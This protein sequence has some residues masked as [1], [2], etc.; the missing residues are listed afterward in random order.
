MVEQKTDQ[1]V[2]ALIIRG[3][4]ILMEQRAP[5][6]KFFPGQIIFIGGKIED[7]ETRDFEKAL[8]REL[9]EELNIEPINYAYLDKEIFGDTGVWLRCFIITEWQGELPDCILDVG[10]PVCW[11][12]IDDMAK[13]EIRF[14]REVIVALQEHKRCL[15]NQL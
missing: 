15:V 14:V 8:K 12:K 2:M 4:E 6:S 5:D 1:A 13:S 10:N 3:D 11:Q 9:K 7:D